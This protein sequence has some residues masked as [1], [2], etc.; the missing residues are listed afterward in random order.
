[1]LLAYQGFERGVATFYGLPGISFWAGRDRDT[2]EMI[3]VAQ[4]GA[5]AARLIGVLSAF[6]RGHRF[7]TL[8]Q[9]RESE[10]AADERR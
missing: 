2:G 1:L 6:I 5:L 9:F 8:G 4:C 7:E 3:Q 10:L